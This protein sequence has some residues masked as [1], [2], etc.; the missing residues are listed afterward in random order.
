MLEW[1]ILYD[2]GAALRSD[3]CVPYDIDARRRHGVLTIVQAEP[4]CGTEP[5]RGSWYVYRTDKAQ[6][7][8]CDDLRGAMDHLIYFTEH[9]SAVLEGRYVTN[10]EWVEVVKQT[11]RV[12][13]MCERSAS[14]RAPVA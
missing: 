11:R 8:A 7:F 14:R 6:W 4:D 1:T 13:D 12:A 9:V 2:D 3:E 10:R 5:L